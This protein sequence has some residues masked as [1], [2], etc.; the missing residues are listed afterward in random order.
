MVSQLKLS[1][2]VEKQEAP[3]SMFQYGTDD[4]EC[5]PPPQESQEVDDVVLKLINLLPA[6][7]NHLKAECRLECSPRP[8][9]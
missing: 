4:L 1:A 8:L 2:K 9:G 7:T 3:H 5:E 6:V